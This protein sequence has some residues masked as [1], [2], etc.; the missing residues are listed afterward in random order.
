MLNG[1]RNY[2]WLHKALRDVWMAGWIESEQQLFWR[3]DFSTG[4]TTHGYK[5]HSRIVAARGEERL[6][7]TAQVS[8]MR[9]TPKRHYPYQYDMTVPIKAFRPMLG[10]RPARLAQTYRDDCMR[11]RAPHRNCTIGC[12][13]P[14]SHGYKRHSEMHGQ[15][16]ANSRNNSCVYFDLANGVTT[17]C[18]NSHSLVI[19]ARVHVRPIKTAPRR[20]CTT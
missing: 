3:R 4:V 1:G 19:A 7:E 5:S 9:S 13:C 12:R 14:R 15:Q 8:A 17:H 16:V 11:G 20:N 6:I 2:T 10:F 18:Y